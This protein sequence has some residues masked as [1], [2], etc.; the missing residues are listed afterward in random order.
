MEAETN[1]DLVVGEP[2]LAAPA[3]RAGPVDE[4][5][6]LI[7]PIV[8]GGRRSLPDDVRLDLELVDEH[9]G[10]PG[11]LPVLGAVAQRH[12]VRNG[13]VQLRCRDG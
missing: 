3:I 8:L 2:N 13:V 12:H 6:L 9:H 7:S 4:Y 5:R 10:E 1:A 11:P